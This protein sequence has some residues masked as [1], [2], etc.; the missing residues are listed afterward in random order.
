MREFTGTWMRHSGDF[1]GGFAAMLVAL[2]ASVAF[3]VT[4]YSA[5][6][7]HH[8]AFGA[9]AGILGAT[10]LG[11][12]APTFGGTDRLISSPCAP[13]AAVL[14]AFAMQL[15][16][17]GVEPFAIVLMMTVLG[18]LTGLLQMLIGFLG[19]GKLIKYIPYPVVSGYLSGVGL[20]I[21]GGQLPTFAGAPTGSRWFEVAMNPRSGICAGWRW[22]A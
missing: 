20:I 14:T 11:L 18:I 5:V 9:L 10:A 8:A 12:I 13:A 6:S 17:Q 1:W 3:G 19:V 21:I 2:P 15:V 7:P 16:T 22:A 4:V